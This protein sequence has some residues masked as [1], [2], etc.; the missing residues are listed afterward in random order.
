MINGKLI[1]LLVEEGYK[2]FGINLLNINKNYIEFRYPGGNIG[3]EVLIDKLMYFSYIYLE[4]SMNISFKL[5]RE[6]TR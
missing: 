1:S 3:R 5:E 4:T 6:F 2:N